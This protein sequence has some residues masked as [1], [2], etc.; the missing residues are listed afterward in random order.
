MKILGEKSKS[1]VDRIIKALFIK[2]TDKN[3]I[4]ELTINNCKVYTIDCYYDNNDF[5]IAHGKWHSSKKVVDALSQ[6]NQHN[7]KIYPI[8]II[9]YTF[10]NPSIANMF[11]L[12]K[13]K[14]CE[15]FMWL[16]IC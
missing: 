11:Y 1:F 2:G 16:R 7:G 8:V 6:I 5:Y 9:N 14:W 12:A 10:D 3:K 4:R 13:Y 15:S